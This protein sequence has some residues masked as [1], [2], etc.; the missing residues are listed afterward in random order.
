MANV[1]RY[2]SGAANDLLIEKTGTTAIEIGDMVLSQDPFTGQLA[3][4]PVLKTTARP[5]ARLFKLVIGDR[6]L[7]CSGGHMFWVPGEGW[8][9]ARDLEEGM[10]LHT[11]QGAVEVQSMHPTG[12]EQSYN[13]VV[14]DFHTYF[15]TEDKL[16]THDNTIREP[17]D[18]V[19][20]GLARR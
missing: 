15:V 8:V 9:K 7:Q 1:M 16:L 20:P 17:V 14:A 18:R 13:L 12:A 10:R 2:R 5:P 19:V 6:S 4:K 11:G 3:Y